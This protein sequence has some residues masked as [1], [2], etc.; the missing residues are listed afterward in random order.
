MSDTRSAVLGE[1]SDNWASR[2]TKQILVGHL[3]QPK[4]ERVSDK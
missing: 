3:A 4:A 2:A 1:M